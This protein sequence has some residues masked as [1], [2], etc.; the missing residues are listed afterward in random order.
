M[1]YD[2]LRREMDI[3]DSHY[4]EDEGCGKCPHEDQ[5]CADCPL[6][7]DTCDGNEHTQE[8]R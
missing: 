7:G 8:E 6:M 2:D 4:A 3:D 5:E 1:D